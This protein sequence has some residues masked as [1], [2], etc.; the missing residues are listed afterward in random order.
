[1]TKKSFKKLPPPSEKILKK[2]E[3]RSLP[4]NG[5]VITERRLLFSFSAFDRHH[6]LFNLGGT[7]EDNTIGGRWFLKLLET[8]KSVCNKTIIE[9]MSKSTHDLHRIN[10]DKAN[11]KPPKGYE[12]LEYW[13]FRLDK[14]SGRIIGTII[15]NVFYILWLDPYHNLTNSEG[16]GGVKYYPEPTLH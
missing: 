7:N 11:A 16:Y 14:S 6:K 13:Q 3:S 12:Q 10:W 2:T 5:S 15:D 4:F 1:M 8:F 9:L